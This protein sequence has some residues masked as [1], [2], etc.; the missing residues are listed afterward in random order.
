M[1]NTMA[2]YTVIQ[3]IAS[4]KNNVFH[5]AKLQEIE[6]SCSLLIDLC[7]ISIHLILVHLHP[8]ALEDHLHGG[9]GDGSTAFLE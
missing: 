2:N 9:L 4:L 1:L 3:I 6:F 5:L 8:H 7:S